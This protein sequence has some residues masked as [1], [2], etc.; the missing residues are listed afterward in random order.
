MSLEDITATKMI[1]SYKI[2][3]NTIQNH[4][5]SFIEFIVKKYNIQDSSFAAKHD[6]ALAQD[7]Y[8]D[9]KMKV[10]IIPLILHM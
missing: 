4:F 8:P 5:T 10:S 6:D 7:E 2:I 9:T 1:K 3:H